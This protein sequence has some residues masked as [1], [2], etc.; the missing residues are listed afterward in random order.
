MKSSNAQQCLQICP[1][2]EAELLLELMFR[3]WSHPYADDKE[4]RSTL[5]ESATELLMRAADP[6]CNEVFIEELPAHEMN[7]VS[8]VWYVEWNSVQNPSE[9]QVSRQ[10]WLDRVRKSV[11]SCFCDT[12]MLD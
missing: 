6:E 2:F 12:N 7:F 5:L 10:Q 1:L 8:A 3:F 4:F 9:D 11:P